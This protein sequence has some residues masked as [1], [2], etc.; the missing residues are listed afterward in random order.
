MPLAVGGVVFA[1]MAT[2][3]W[4]RKAT[5]AAY[6]Q[7]DHDHCRAGQ[8]CIAAARSFIERNALMMS[9]RP[10][11][12]R[13]GDR[14]PGADRMMWERYGMLPRNLI[15]V[16]VTTARSPTSTT[17]AIRSPCSTATS[18][19][20]QRHRRRTVSFGFMEEPDVEAALEDMARHHEI[21]LPA[22]PHQWIVHIM[23]DHLLPAR[24]NNVLK[25]LRLSL[26]QFL[27]AASRPAY[28]YYGL[29]DAVQLTIE[30]IPVRL[31]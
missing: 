29:G 20:R 30:V 2:W 10:A 8:R 12:P 23:Q 26:F 11:A 28:S 14:A 25:R 24:R 6:R 19:Q 22:D 5:F 31:R 3:R 17:I 21:D 15:F 1:V 7:G 27:A 16:E 13:T 9:P 4:G 18:E